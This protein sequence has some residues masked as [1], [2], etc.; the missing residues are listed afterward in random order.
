MDWI[1]DHAWESWLIAG[2]LLGVIEMVSLDLIFA[3][4]AVGCVVGVVTA[5]VGLG[6]PF[7]VLLALASAVGLLAFLRPNLIRSLHAGPD[8][9]IGPAA[10][11][12]GEIGRAHV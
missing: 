7:Q 2:M 5:L 6:G 11:E 3:M 4:L 8:L 12:V 10:L 9:Q 1:R